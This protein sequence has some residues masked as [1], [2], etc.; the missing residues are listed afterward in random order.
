MQNI[1]TLLNE[2]LNNL[3]N[4]LNKVDRVEIFQTS[5]KALNDCEKIVFKDAAIVLGDYTFKNEF[6]SVGL[7]KIRHSVEVLYL[8][9]TD[10]ALELSTDNLNKIISGLR[11]YNFLVNTL[12]L[13]NMSTGFEIR[14]LTNKIS[15]LTLQYS[16]IE[17]YKR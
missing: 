3:V 7:D 1:K 5:D 13:G 8:M 2:K 10:S 6:Y 12:V 4:S 14:Q 15:Y 17:I 11:N 16:V 9:K